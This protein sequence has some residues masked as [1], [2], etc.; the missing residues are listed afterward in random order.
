MKLEAHFR[1]DGQAVSSRSGT[2]DCVPYF[3]I[4]NEGRV[5]DIQVKASRINLLLFVS[6][7]QEQTLEEVLS[8][9]TD[10]PCFVV[11]EEQGSLAHPNLFYD[12][13]VFRLFAD[14][15]ATISAFICQ[16]NSKI[17]HAFSASDVPQL[18]ILLPRYE[19]LPYRGAPPPVILVPNVISEELA[20]RLIANLKENVETSHQTHTDY[21]SRIHVHPNK[22]LELA[23]DDKLGKSLLPEIAKVFYSDI[24][25]RETYKTCCYSADDLGCFG[26]HRDTI[27]PHVHRRYAMTLVLN[28]DFESG[29]IS[30]PEYSDEVIE[31]PKT[32]AVVS[33]GSLFHQINTIGVGRRYVVISFFFS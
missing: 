4:E 22:E 1:K 32:W 20:Q 21:K 28:D 16:R 11:T 31:V 6:A 33:P 23:H 25:H 13:A 14:S 15:D 30:F 27:A 18:S 2:G 9:N 10:Y 26:K 29:G 19:D 24:S 17:S 7:K 3:F 8:L 5:L 12:A